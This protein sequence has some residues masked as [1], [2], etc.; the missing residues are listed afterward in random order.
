MTNEVLAYLSFIY[1]FFLVFIYFFA[2]KESDI[3]SEKAIKKLNPTQ[4]ALA[5]KYLCD[6]DNNT[7]LTFG[8][9]WQLEYIQQ[10]NM[11]EEAALIRQKE[12]IERQKRMIGCKKV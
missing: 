11:E 2:K 8:K 5:V 9:L 10:K 12:N 4:K 6:P 1:I 7:P 3:L